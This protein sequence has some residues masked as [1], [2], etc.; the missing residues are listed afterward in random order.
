LVFR[1]SALV[2]K[3]VERVNLEK[4]PGCLLLVLRGKAAEPLCYDR[5]VEPAKEIAD[6]L[7]A[8]GRTNDNCALKLDPRWP[9]DASPSSS[10]L[11]AT[12]P[13]DDDVD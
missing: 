8:A 12:A 6:P 7:I 3:E 10:A 5:I 1:S 4:Q 9:V 13:P 11:H 2:A